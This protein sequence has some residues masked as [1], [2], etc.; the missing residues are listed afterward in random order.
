[1]DFNFNENLE[2]ESLNKIPTQFQ[3]LYKEV[4]GKH[5]LDTEDPKVKGAVEGITAL[6]K[7]LIS[8]RKNEKVS[9]EKIS[10]EILSKFSDYGEDP[11]SILEAFNSK[12]SELQGEL[13]KGDKAK[14]NL[15]KIK[16]DLAEAHSKD[17]KAKDA[18]VE[19]LSG[20]LNKLLVE[21]AAT[22][23]VAEEKGVPELLMPFIRDKVKVIEEDGELK[24]F[25]VDGDGER[26][27]SGVTGSPMTIKELVREMKQNEK[28]GRLFE[29]ETPSGGGARPGSTQQRIQ[30]KS[31]EERNSVDKIS[32]GLAKKRRA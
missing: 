14:I 13:A 31:G 25:V 10:T 6:N 32:A 22:T 17:L 28:Y 15:D 12:V 30:Q 19:A 21:N 23:A 18:K 11:D 2:V 24:V 7:A 29:S 9:R 26:R 3:P 4:D 8:A 16:Q 27:Y 5:V 20:Q 1:M